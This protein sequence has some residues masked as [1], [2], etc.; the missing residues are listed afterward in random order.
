MSF[1]PAS[2]DLCGRLGLTQPIFNAPMAGAAGGRLAAAVSSAGGLGMVGIGGG[3]AT[4]WLQRELALAASS[5]KPWGAGLMAWVLSE[6]LEP[7]RVVLEHRP[8]LVGISFGDPSAAAS[9]ARDAGALVAMQ[10]GNHADLQRALEDDIDVVV[11][12]GSEGG[13]HGRN[14]VAT[15]PLLQLAL[16]QTEKPVLAAGGI[17]TA[18]GV[19]AVLAAGAQGAWIG[20]R[21]AACTESTSPA[22]AKEAIAGAGTDDTVYT[23]AFD[24]AQQV[25]WPAEFGGR[26]LR[27]QFSD[28]WADDLEA[29]QAEVASAPR[30]TEAIDAARRDADVAQAPVYA[31]QSAG[32]TH[33][34]ETAAEVVA[35][36]AG[37]RAHLRASASRW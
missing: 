22:R 26:A 36:L 31:G 6:S 24:I 4:D 27:N 7:L 5:G 1:S 30:I 15:L 16:D 2:D 34:G 17:A 35:D 23:R 37:F 25:P 28:R 20:T 8:N 13:G 12:R 32:I 21:F 11:V 19:A 10:V 18:R 3:V 29:L 14:E 9:M 33:G